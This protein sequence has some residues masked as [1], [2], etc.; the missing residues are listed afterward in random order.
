VDFSKFKTSDWLVIGGGIAMLIFGLFVDWASLGGASGN[1]AFD[2]FFTGGLAWLLVVAAGVVAVLRVTGKL[3]ST[4]PWPLLVLAATALGA[5][6]MLLRII[7]GGGSE[8]AAGFSVDLDRGAGMYLAFIAAL[9]AAA[10]GVLGFKES[11]GE[12]SDLKDFDKLKSAFDKDGGTPP[13]PP[14][15]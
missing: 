5:L 4:L 14:S 2:Y 6:L 8:S 10:G 15:A 3:P 13:P 9:A 1:N 7:M 12:L 11:G